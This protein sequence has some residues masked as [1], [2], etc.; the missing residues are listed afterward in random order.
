MLS[1][2]LVHVHT[3]PAISIN[4]FDPLTLS[5]LLAIASC[6]IFLLYWASSK[7]RQA[8]IGSSV[9]KLPE[10]TPA[11]YLALAAPLPQ[12]GTHAAVRQTW[13][14][15]VEES[16]GQWPPKPTWSYPTPLL[17]DLHKLAREAPLLFAR[18]D[19][20]SWNPDEDIHANRKWLVDR[21]PNSD[22]TLAD[23]RSLSDQRQFIG[24]C[25]CITTLAHLYRWGALPILKQAQDD[26]IS[27]LPNVLLVAMQYCN[28][29]IGIQSTGGTA[30]TLGYY[31][32]DRENDLIPYS[33]TMNFDEA[34]RSSELWTIKLFH[35]M[36]TVVA[37]F[38]E[39]LQT[40]CQE[41]EQGIDSRALDKGNE[42]LKASFGFFFKNLKSPNVEKSVWSRYVQG[43][44][45]WSWD[46]F[47]GFSGN[48]AFLVRVLD[49]LLGIPPVIEPTH[50]TR[51]QRRFV[52]SL[53]SV[54]LRELVAEKPNATKALAE[55]IK[56]LKTWRM[57]HSK[58]AVHYE[59]VELPE[60]KPMSGGYG[61][62]ADVGL[63]GML[64]RM[65]ER[66]KERTRLTA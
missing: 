63:S 44:H 18:R 24:M 29:R 61:T 33:V 43:F 35:E 7:H 34:S 36:E 3:M 55:T 2:Y 19:V 40:F 20:T 48:Q 10:P 54:R 58:K 56:T 12:R 64:L 65:T 11:Q 41:V 6:T 9:T 26:T 8:K 13:L 46:G 37:P 17:Q 32:F 14:E 53:R 28:N 27:H 42:A 1:T 23:L 39:A 21:L 31:N 51:G 25:C 16:G 50:L 22:D 52:D 38:Y 49:A 60:R 45:G 30:T 57:G 15:L 66:F 4:T 47:E 62:D 5:V 59:D